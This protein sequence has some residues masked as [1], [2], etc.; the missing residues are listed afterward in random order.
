MKHGHK[1]TKQEYF[2]FFNLNSTVREKQRLA[3]KI[4]ER[5]HYIQAHVGNVTF[6][7]WEDVFKNLENTGVRGIITHLDFDYTILSRHL[8]DPAPVKV[9]WS[10]TWLN[11]HD[12]A[13]KREE[14][15]ADETNKTYFTKHSE[16][17]QKI[18]L[19][20]AKQISKDWYVF[21]QGLLH[22]IKTEEE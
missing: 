1:I 17:L 10:D 18:G 15:Q 6:E 2:D 5:I 11:K 8:D 9:L 4:W 20:A 22:F 12:A 3:K 21:Q 14:N 19:P 7:C 16:V 13:L